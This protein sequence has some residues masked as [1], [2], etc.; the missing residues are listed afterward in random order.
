MPKGP[1]F[2]QPDHSRFS[3]PK[4]INTIQDLK[5]HFGP[6]EPDESVTGET[7]MP[8]I[9]PEDEPDEQAKREVWLCLQHFIRRRDE[10]RRE[11]WN[12]ED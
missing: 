5:R 10:R 11:K 4:D 2:E 8:A 6:P 3:L 7:V 12:P 9:I 1:D